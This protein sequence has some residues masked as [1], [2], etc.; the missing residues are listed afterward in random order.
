MRKKKVYKAYKKEVN[1]DDFLDKS[2]DE[3]K[4]MLLDK[5]ERKKLWQKQHSKQK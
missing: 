4:Q 5:E 3:M 2:E 1:L